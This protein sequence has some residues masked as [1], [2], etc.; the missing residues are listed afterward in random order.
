MTTATLSL[1]LI[2]LLVLTVTPDRSPDST[3]NGATTARATVTFAALERPALPI[4]TPIGD[5]GWGV[6]TRGA[7]AGRSGILSARLP[8]GDIVDVKVM[9][10]DATS[11]LTVVSLPAAEHGYELADA[12]PAPSDT[13]L[14]NGEPPLVVAMDDL[15]ALNVDE[16]TPVLDGDGD[17]VGLCTAGEHGTAL[18]PVATMPPTTARPTTSAPPISAPTTT[19]PPP[20]TAATTSSSATS[21]TTTSVASSTTTPGSTS[22]VSGG[23]ASGAPG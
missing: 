8:S 17:L 21:T 9:R 14:V 4:V 23:G 11:G 18:R 20:T 1:A 10:T 6:T 2:G 5:E 15:A 22:T 19:L 7:V 3:S 12:A 16:G 13:V